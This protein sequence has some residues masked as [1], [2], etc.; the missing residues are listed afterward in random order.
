MFLII[1]CFVVLNPV[2]HVHGGKQRGMTQRPDDSLGVSST[3]SPVSLLTSFRSFVI[4]LL[5][6][7][8]DNESLAYWKQVLSDCQISSFCMCTQRYWTQKYV[9]WELAVS[10]VTLSG[11]IYKFNSFRLFKKKK[12][13]SQ[14]ECFHILSFN[15]LVMKFGSVFDIIC[16]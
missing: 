15:R 12:K 5:P 4:L 10:Y 9:F 11:Y 14:F 6:L 16:I 1:S 8:Q 2:F 13:K 3:N 7:L